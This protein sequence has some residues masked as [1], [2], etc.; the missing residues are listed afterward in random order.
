MHMKNPQPIQSST[1]VDLRNG[2]WIPSSFDG[3]YSELEALARAIRESDS[4]P[5]FRGHRRREWRLDSTFARSA[6]AMLFDMKPEEGYSSRLAGSGD[7]NAALCSLLLLK[8]GT[9][10]EPSAEL[11]AV[12]AE[13]GVDT[14]FELMKRYQQYPEED[15]PVLRGTNFLDW[16]KSSDVALH[17][18]N[19]DRDGPGALFICDAAATGKS[20]QLLPV[21]DILKKVREQLMRGV[22]N[23]APLMFSPPRQILNQ[24]AKNQEVVY[25]AQ[26]ELRADLRELWRLVENEPGRET[27][28]VKLVV[29][30]GTED[31]IH[32]YLV[33]KGIDRTFI[34]PDAPPRPTRVR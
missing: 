8:F 13:H 34:Y 9:V 22:S 24:R 30:E 15:T 29:P 3:F 12:Q 16:S 1:K 11:V 25:F 19:E 32:S 27:I 28:L 6:K 26:M 17:F 5:L 23:G 33:S 21:I 2:D 10:L 31:E 7:L 4:M 20:L 14:W 18:A